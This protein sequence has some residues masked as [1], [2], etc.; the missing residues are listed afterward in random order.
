[1]NANLFNIQS[2]PGGHE[3]NKE[4]IE[5]LGRWLAQGQRHNK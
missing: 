5:D 3:V 1:M 2:N 4:E